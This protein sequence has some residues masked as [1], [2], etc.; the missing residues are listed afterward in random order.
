MQRLERELAQSSDLNTS[1]VEDAAPKMSGMP[2]T[3]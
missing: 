1:C 3:L 2:I